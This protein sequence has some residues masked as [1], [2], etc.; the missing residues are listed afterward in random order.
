MTQCIIIYLHEVTMM[1]SENIAVN[2]GSKTPLLD[3]ETTQHH[4]QQDALFV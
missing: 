3:L 1:G 2:C 4:Q